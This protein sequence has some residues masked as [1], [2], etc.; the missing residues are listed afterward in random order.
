MLIVDNLSLTK[1]KRTILKS[2]SLT[3]PKGS[4]TLLLGKS[5]AGKSSLLRCMAQL[6]VPDSGTISCEGASLLNLGPQRR[7]L[8]LSFIAQ[9][10]A[11][12]PHLTALDNCA[13]PLTIVSKEQQTMARQKALE[14]LALLGMEAYAQSFPQQLSGGQQQRVAIA[15]ALALNP[16][17]LLLDEPTAALDPYNTASLIKILMQLRHQGKG[18]V[19]STQD[20]DFASQ[21]LEHA[22]LLEE[23]VMVDSYPNSKGLIMQFLK[24][25]WRDAP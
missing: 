11:L 3:C 1:G 6:E 19:I 15:R 12:F 20:M 2:I 10:Y 13:Q 16:A 25:S 24:K 22:V 17:Y 4:I 18:I 23:G 8:L 21:L 9:S 5:G 14:I 7:A